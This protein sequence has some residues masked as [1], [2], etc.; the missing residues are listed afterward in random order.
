MI[1]SAS[2]DGEADLTSPSKDALGF[3]MASTQPLMQ[4]ENYGLAGLHNIAEI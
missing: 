4:L 2:F 1:A 3:Q